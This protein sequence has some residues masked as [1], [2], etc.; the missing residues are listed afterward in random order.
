[1]YDKLTLLTPNWPAPAQVK[2]A[3]SCRNTGYSQGVYTA[4]NLALHVDDDPLLVAK[5]RR[6]LQHQ[7]GVQ[8]IQWL[9]Q[10]HGTHVAN[11][12]PDGL[13]RTADA[14]I[15]EQ[16]HLACSVMTADCL[17][18]LL[19]DQAGTQVAA[20]H[21]GWRGLAKGVIAETVKQFTGKPNQLLA[22]LGPAISKTHFEVGVDVLEA[23]FE[24]AGNSDAA[25]AIAN[26]FQPSLKPLKFYADL[27]ALARLALAQAGVNNIYGG[28]FCTF[29]DVDRFYSY[30]RDGQTGRMASLIWLD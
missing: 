18:L 10:V 24:L 6:A 3:I 11:A 29:S 7:I 4:G 17:P 22:Y 2:V 16:T 8:H 23:F 20:V 21:A 13:T 19:C 15:T 27:Y 26:A 9:E 1:M 30:R 28:D 5:N 12:L 14:C 25:D